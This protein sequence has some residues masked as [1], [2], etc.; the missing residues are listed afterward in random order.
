MMIQLNH[1]PI[2]PSI[3]SILQYVGRGSFD[4]YSRFKCLL[5]YVQ[6]FGGVEIMYAFLCYHKI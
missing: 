6:T 4:A 2:V 5:M 3:Q 1:M